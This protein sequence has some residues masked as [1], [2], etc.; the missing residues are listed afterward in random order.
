MIR[1]NFPAAFLPAVRAGRKACTI[2]TWPD[3]WRNRVRPGQRVDLAFGRRD[4]P[5]LVPAV[6][7]AVDAYDLA[8][9]VAAYRAA[10]EGQ[11]VEVEVPEGLLDALRASAGEELGEDDLAEA[12]EG[13]LAE[14][15]ERGRTTALAIWFKLQEDGHDRA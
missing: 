2:R 14:L 7:E 5:V 11:E 12:V 3:A 13:L 1:L 15:A 10:A 4:R 6:I 9:A 8:E